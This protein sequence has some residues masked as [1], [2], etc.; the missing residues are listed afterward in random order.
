MAPPYPT[1]QIL[2]TSF[3]HPYRFVHCHVPF[4]PDAAFKPLFPFHNHVYSI[5]AYPSL[6]ISSYSAKSTQSSW[7]TADPHA[8]TSSIAASQ[9]ALMTGFASTATATWP[10][11]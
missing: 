5:L 7:R 9:E 4:N 1:Q 11:S 10:D 6:Q 2:L 3:R 8:A